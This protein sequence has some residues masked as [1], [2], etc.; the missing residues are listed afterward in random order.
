MRW[1]IS[2]MEKETW[3][4]KTACQTV[5]LINVTN[6]KRCILLT[7]FNFS[8]VLC[9]WQAGWWKYLQTSGGCPDP[10]CGHG[11][12]EGEAFPQ[13]CELDAPLWRWPR[14]WVC[15]QGSW[16]TSSG[17]SQ[18]A[19]SPGSSEPSCLMPVGGV[20]PQRWT[21]CPHCLLLSKSLETRDGEI[22]WAEAYW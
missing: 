2:N 13:V 3:S 10:G 4:T 1:F 12:E 7:T 19:W 17:C 14:R 21:C 6:K 18:S 20:T 11:T 15:G 5:W 16:A 8:P 22:H 9:G